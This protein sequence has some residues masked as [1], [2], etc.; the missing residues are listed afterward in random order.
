MGALSMDRVHTGMFAVVV[1]LTG[2]AAV[3]PPATTADLR[4]Q[5]MDTERAFARSMA[6][7]DF[8]AF[9]GFLSP[10]ATFF[11]ATRVLHGKQEVADAWKRF[12]DNPAAPFSWKPETVEVLE[13]G[14]LAL[15]SGPVFDP[16]GK[17][18]ATFTSIWRMEAP[19]TWR[20]VFDKGND[21]CDCAKQP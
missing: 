7:R 13:S 14:N 19:G 12:F 4:M 9:T 20:I 18:F 10:E 17:Q 11:S 8:S 3:P 21:V 5:V 1:L 6:D 15:S 16:A 2:C